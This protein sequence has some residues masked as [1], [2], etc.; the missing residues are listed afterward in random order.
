MSSIALGR[1]S[2]WLLLWALV[3]ALA[4]CISATQLVLNDKGSI[5]AEELSRYQTIYFV[6]PKEDPRN[7]TPRVVAALQQ[8]KYDVILMSPDD[9]V[10]GSQG[11]GFVI[12][13]DGHVLTCDHVLAKMNEATI[14]VKGKRYFA[15]VVA[16]DEKLDIAL[17]KIRDLGG[18]QLQ[19][20][21]FRRSE[22]YALGEDVFTIGYPMS[23]ILGD[24]ARM[25]KGLLSSTA[26]IKDNPDQV[27]ISAEI[28]PGNSGG[29][30][31]DSN[32]QVIGIVQQTLN[33]WMV[34]RETGGALPQNVNFA[35]KSSRVL[36][37]IKTSAPD[38]Y[39]QIQFDST[40]SF[41]LVEPSVVKLRSGIITEEW[42]KKPK[43]VMGLYYHSI[44]DLW[45]RFR[46]F[47]IRV[48]DY[49][50]GEFLFAAGQGRDTVVSTEDK[51]IDDTLAQV[52]A[53]LGR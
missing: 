53:A 31:L 21:G 15:D 12:T 5:K 45:Y 51:V 37:F 52:R 16:Q 27:Q 24:S 11:T 13:R 36:E 39:Q 14:T 44:W 33:P 9:K 6:K 49:D 17:L 48:L 23:S 50:T 20:L 42:E 8:M 2:R 46:V 19:P 29:P 7:V 22:H 10:L 35:N 1:V 4:G 32:A 43:L 28:A 34:A 18:D 30:V 3:P 47:V 41:A 40:S 38:V 26:G 25:T